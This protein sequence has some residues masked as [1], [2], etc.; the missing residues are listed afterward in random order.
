[1]MF[2]NPL[3]QAS[4]GWPFG[5]FITIRAPTRSHPTYDACL[6]RT[7]DASNANT[8]CDRGTSKSE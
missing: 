5:S 1:M 3:N 2:E 7:K 8:I 6:G 4:P